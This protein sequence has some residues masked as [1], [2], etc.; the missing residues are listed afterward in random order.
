M[1]IHN[2]II[3]PV[4]IMTSTTPSIR[5]RKKRH[6]QRIEQRKLAREREAREH[7]NIPDDTLDGQIHRHID[8]T[9]DDTYE[10]V[11][12]LQP[13]SRTSSQPERCIIC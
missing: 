10:F 4:I 12:D 11:V 7:A 5:R 1:Q 8:T 9:L 3:T 2:I 13:P 6:Q